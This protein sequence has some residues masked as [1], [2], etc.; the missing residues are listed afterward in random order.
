MDVF[1]LIK[2]GEIIL[3]IG[4]RDEFEQRLCRQLEGKLAGKIIRFERFPGRYF[5][6]V[7]EQDAE[8]AEFAMRSTPGINGYSRAIKCPKD[9][10]AILDAAEGIATRLAAAGATSFKAETRV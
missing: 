3:K 5:L 2:L 10:A 9:M 8:R 1:Y 7:D 4:N 6:T